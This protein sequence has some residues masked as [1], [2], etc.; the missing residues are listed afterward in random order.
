MLKD[1]KPNTTIIYIGSNSITKLNYQNIN[2]VEFTK[3]KVNIEL[4][5]KY[6]GVGLIDISSIFARSNDVIKQ[7]L[8]NLN[9]VIK[10]VNF[11]LTNL[12]KAYGFA[13]I[14][15]EYI[16]WNHLWRDGIHLI[17]AGKSLLFKNVSENLNSVFSSE[18]GF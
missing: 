3:E 1:K 17:N 16:D 9:K 11:S 15:N 13:F 6:Y 5:C 14:C 12:S 4:K 7:D 18:Y 2:A 8:N 10:Q